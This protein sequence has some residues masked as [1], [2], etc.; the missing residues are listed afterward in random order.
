M[1]WA[2]TKSVLLIEASSNQ[3]DPELVPLCTTT[4]L[5]PAGF[6]ILPTPLYLIFCWKLLFQMWLWP[7]WCSLLYL[8]KEKIS[9]FFF[10]LSQYLVPTP[11][12]LS[13]RWLGYFCRRV[14]QLSAAV[15]WQLLHTGV[16]RDSLRASFM[17][18]LTL[19]PIPAALGS[20]EPPVCQQ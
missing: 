20:N 8:T 7:K 1:V 6:P 2:Y 5:L 15:L 16:M 13:F 12:F 17:P 11:S 9:L 19:K 3:K 18:P 10:F 4:P 14:M